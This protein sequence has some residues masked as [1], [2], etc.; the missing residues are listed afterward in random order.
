MDALATSLQH[1]RDRML[2]KPVDLH[3]RV[4]LAQLVS[5]RHIALRM[6]KADRRGDV[7]HALGAGLAADPARRR[8]RGEREVTQEQVDLDR[9]APM[10]AMTRALEEDE[11]ATSRLGERGSAARPG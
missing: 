1:L 8:P 10:R 9:I 3:I 6:A 5:D 11:V 4:Q 2:G 7:Q